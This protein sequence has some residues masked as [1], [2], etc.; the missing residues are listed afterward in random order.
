MKQKLEEQID[1]CPIFYI[2]PMPCND[3][4]FIA[5]NICWQKKNYTA[6]LNHASSNSSLRSRPLRNDQPVE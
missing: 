1:W 3:T 6:I 4:N 2:Q 5:V